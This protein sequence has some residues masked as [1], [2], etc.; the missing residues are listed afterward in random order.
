MA[1]SAE[2]YQGQCFC[3]AVKIEVSGEPA[4]AGICH[5]ESCQK[6]HAAPIAAFALWPKDSVRITQGEDILGTFNKTGESARRWCTQ[7]GSNVLN[8]KPQM[9]MVV[10]YAPVLAPSKMI[11]RPSLHLFYEERALDINDG[12][13]KYADVPEQFGGSGRQIEESA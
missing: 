9:D 13:P 3:G 8:E 2:T 4:V 10:V 11:A 6:W 5:C 1:D 7:C 12:L